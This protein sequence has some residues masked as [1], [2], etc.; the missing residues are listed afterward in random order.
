[1]IKKEKKAEKICYDEYRFSAKELVQY[2]LEALAIIVSISYLFYHSVIPFFVGL[3]CLP[4]Y[5][6]KK[7]GACILK[8]KEKIKLQFKEAITAFANALLVG[9]SIENAFIE[10]YEDLKLIYD[11]EEEFMKELRFMIHQL[12]NNAVLETLLLDFAQRVQISDVMDFAQ[13][14]VVAKRSGGNISNMMQQTAK[15]IGDKIEVKREIRTILAAKQFEQKIMNLIPIAIV[16]YIHITSPN[17]FDVLYGNVAG[18]MIMTACLVVYLI[19]LLLAEK[20]THIEME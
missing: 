11:E 15:T 6:K 14:F 2:L 16:A 5:L 13:V 1:M 9:Y 12:K 3:L 20:I 4:F 17:Y 10:A 18:V 7:K 19:A 8:R